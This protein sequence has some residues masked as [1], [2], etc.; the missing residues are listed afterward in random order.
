MIVSIPWPLLRQII[1]IVGI[2]VVLGFVIIIGFDRLRRLRYEYRERLAA[3]YPYILLLA[4]TLV[5]NS[6]IRN[7]G[8]GLSWLL[9]IQITGLIYS[10]DGNLVATI[11]SYATDELTQ[12]FTY[13]YIYGYV[14]LMVFPFFAYLAKDEMQSFR[15]LMLAYTF[16]Y[17][18]GVICYI[19][20]IAYG[21]R[22]WLYPDV[23][24]LMYIH[25]PQSQIITGE[26][27]SNTNVFPSLH[28]SIALTVM[29]LANRTR[30]TYPL[31]LLV[32]TPLAICVLI[33]TMYLGI[34]W[35]VDV[36]AGAVL[37]VI[38]VEGAKH[39]TDD[40]GRNRY[41]DGAAA[42]I[43]AALLYPL[44]VAREWLSEIR[45]GMDS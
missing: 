8:Q 10:I 26:I 30:D 22:N 19:L 7:N 42:R 41:I 39:L 12:F 31:W 13:I 18:I 5:L 34:H 6:F 1:L 24:S 29:L 11:Q 20:F 16:N 44:Y 23:R 2:L 40:Q 36:V 28:S 3:V 32:S 43:V 38:S 14:F 37:A 15:E 27:N 17:T 45:A 25:W 9:D 33:A 35:G 21:P 4:I